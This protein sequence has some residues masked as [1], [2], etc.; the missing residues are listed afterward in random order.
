MPKNAV[1]MPF[2]S[3]RSKIKNKIR[4]SKMDSSEFAMVGKEEM[5]KQ[6]KEKVFLFSPD[7]PLF[8]KKK[9]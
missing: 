8:L 1:V 3:K 5:L 6:G 9:I 4:A 7:P 2:Y